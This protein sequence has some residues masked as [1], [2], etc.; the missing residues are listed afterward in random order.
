MS[1]RGGRP[2]WTLRSSCRTMC[3]PSSGFAA[4]GLRWVRSS[5]PSRRQVLVKSIVFVAL[6]GSRSGSAGTSIT[7]SVMTTISSAFASTSRRIRFGGRRGK[8]VSPAFGG[9]GRVTTRPYVDGRSGDFV[10][11]PRGAPREAGRSRRFRVARL[12]RARAGYD[13]PLRRRQVRRFRRGD[14][15]V[16]LAGRSPA[17]TQAFSRGDPHASEGR[18]GAPRG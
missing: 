7:S 4:T 17:R 2:T 18:V 11:P 10:R 5:A 16:A 8:P 3:M 13:P 1:R 9:R 15:W 6:L 12:W 14:P